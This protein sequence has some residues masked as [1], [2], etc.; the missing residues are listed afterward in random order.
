[1]T[2]RLAEGFSVG[3]YVKNL[4]T[5]DVELVAEG[6]A[7]DVDEF[8]NLVGQ[9]MASYIDDSSIEERAPGRFTGFHIRH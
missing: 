9:R 8:L 7:K 4:P 2:E 6:E 5:G 3:G 1:M